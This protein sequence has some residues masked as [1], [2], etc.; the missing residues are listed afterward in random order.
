MKFFRA[1]KATAIE[2]VG[3]IAVAV[4]FGLVA[5]PLGVIVAGACAVWVAQG[6]EVE[7]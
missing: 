1:H 5:L 4:G 2:L 6:L 3:Y 7:S